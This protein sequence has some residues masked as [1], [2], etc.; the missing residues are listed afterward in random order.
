MMKK[1]AVGLLPL[2]IA[3]TSF[4]EVLSIDIE[5]QEKKVPV[6]FYNENGSSN[7]NNDM[8]NKIQT[9]I[10]KTKK[11]DILKSN[12]DT[13]INNAK[14]KRTGLYCV[15]LKTNTNSYPENTTDVVIE[16]VG[17]SGQNNY[18]Q[19]FSFGNNKDAFYNASN[20]V[21]DFV[22]KTIFNQNS[23]F[24]SKLAYVKS[25]RTNNGIIYNL[26]T[27][28][29]DGS[30][31][32]VYLTSKAPILSIDWS[33]DNSKL[34]YVSYEKVRSGIF[35]HDLKTGARTQ[36]TNY[37]G[38]N[39][40]P[41]WN[42]NGKSIVMSLSK[43]GSSDIYIYELSSKMLFKVTNDRTADETEPTW[44]NSEEIV[45]TSNK[46]GNP[47]LYKFNIISKK[48]SLLQTQYGY[49]TTPKV[50]KD[51]SFVVATFKNGS[52]YGLIKINDNRKVSLITKDYFGE[53]PTVS[54]NNKLIMYSTK[55]KTA[56]GTTNGLKAVDLEGTELF[57]IG[58]NV[59]SIKEPALSN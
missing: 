49:V 37:K 57:T 15:H 11:A 31:E 47:N 16:S 26:A 20:Q 54:A 23:Y 29:I 2:I 39:G 24:N 21:S 34:V 38:I 14:N 3:N 55:V 30:N 28:N 53:S 6:I 40:F 4:A 45:Y 50:S 8:Y 32:Q 41:S 35:I 59:S 48:T 19:K 13:C 43:D 33:P 5:V 27:S 22:Y 42:P 51:G 18:T 17:F 36:L 12:G 46:T 52:N 9:N 10:F 44:L 7:Y 25:A 58:S 56:N 1:I